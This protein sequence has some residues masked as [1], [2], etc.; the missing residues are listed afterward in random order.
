[1]RL[2]L[3]LLSLVTT[4]DASGKCRADNHDD[5]LMFIR[6]FLLFVFSFDEKSVQKK[7]SVIE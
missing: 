7:S 1:M 6:F 2:L 5:D 3:A 4:L